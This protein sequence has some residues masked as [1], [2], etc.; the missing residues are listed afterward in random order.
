MGCSGEPS[1]ET[2]CII[3]DSNSDYKWQ[4][5][6]PPGGKPFGFIIYADKT[7]LSSFGSTMGYPVFARL[8]NLPESF[9]NS[10]GYAGGRLV[11][12]LPIVCVYSLWIM[13]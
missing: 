8:A 12:W 4:S 5:V 7:K 9:R 1:V 13:V 10:R 2:S 11:G 6:L 3:M